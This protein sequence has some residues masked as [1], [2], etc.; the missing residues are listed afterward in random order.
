MWD[1]EYKFD[2]SKLKDAH[3]RCQLLTEKALQLDWTVIVSNTFTTKKELKP[4]F[5]LAKKFEIIPQVILCQNQFGNVH[6]V[7]DEVLKRMKLRFEYD[8]SDLFR[9]LEA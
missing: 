3:A 7:P 4:Y 2:Q 1:G 9:E 6:G 5:D 8:I